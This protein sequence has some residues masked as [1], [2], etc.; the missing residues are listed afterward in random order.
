MTDP[1]P[2]PVKTGTQKREEKRL[3]EPPKK[4][5]KPQ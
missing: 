1:A 5:R 2:R 3:A 4:D